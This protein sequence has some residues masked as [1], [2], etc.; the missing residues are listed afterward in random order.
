[1][2]AYGAAHYTTTLDIDVIAL[3]DTKYFVGPHSFTIQNKALTPVT[4]TL[5]NIGAITVYGIYT[6]YNVPESFPPTLFHANA[7]I[8][9]EPESVTIPGNSA[10]IIITHFT[11]PVVVDQVRLPVYGGYVSI[12]GSNGEVLTL[13][14]AGAAAELKDTKMMGGG[15]GGFLLDTATDDWIKDFNFTFAGPGSAYVPKRYSQIAIGLSMG[16]PLV[17][18][19][20]VPRYVHDLVRS[21]REPALSPLPGTPWKH[22]PRGTLY[23]QNRNGKL[24]S[25]EYAPEGEYR[26]LVRAL[27][28]FGDP[29]Q[30]HDYEEWYTDFIYI[31]YV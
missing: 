6:E 15:Y 18:V 12:S 8:R 9:F 4:Y 3:N 23:A 7:T 29:S 14:H 22:V 10:A 31:S 25:G 26:F 1:V 11:R 19:E 27:W 28:L 17:Q 13:P 24:E 20:I 30:R 2:D 21:I 16:S 5:S